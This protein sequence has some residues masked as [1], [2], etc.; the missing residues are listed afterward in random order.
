MRQF[1]NFIFGLLL[2]SLIVGATTAV[3]AYLTKQ[4][5]L[6]E[7][8]ISTATLDLATVPQSALINFDGVLPG[9]NSGERII[10]LENTGSANLKYT[11][12][13]EPNTA[14]DDNELYQE[15]E[16]SLYEY[17]ENQQL[18]KEYGGEGSKLEDL[19]NVEMS[20]ILN[21]GQEKELGIE[22]RLSQDVDNEI[23]GLTTNFKLIFNAIQE[24]GVF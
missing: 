24:D 23:Q 3:K 11:V 13:V 9:F 5:I 4:K 7:S 18:V 16:Y 8:S 22:V 14:E 20:Q 10:T 12:S 19:K 15:L 17:D 21:V 1:K 6:G 2:G